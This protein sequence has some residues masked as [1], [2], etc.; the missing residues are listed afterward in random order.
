MKIN[1][2]NTALNLLDKWDEEINLP[3]TG[4]ELTESE[5]KN[6]GESLLKNL[7][8]TK[9][10]FGKNIQYVSR[11]F[12]EAY[13]KGRG[14][15][16]GVFDKEDIMEGG[17]LIYTS[18]SWTKTIFYYLNVRATDNENWHPDY[19]LIEFSKHSKNDFKS[20]DV[21]IA[22]KDGKERTFLW[23]GHRDEGRDHG[24][25]FAFLITFILFKKYV[26]LETKEIKANKRGYH[27]GTKYVNETK[28][29]ITIL[30]STWFTTIVRSEGF[31]VRGHFRMQPYGPGATKR[32]LQWIPTFEKEGYTRIAK[33]LR[34]ESST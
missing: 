22:S 6:F 25:W 8:R 9:D 27:A 26:A 17:T 16:A 32:R 5:R 11:P 3:E 29:N 33:M 1:Y 20:L 14:K 21:Y 31:A 19:T 28:S 4:D 18:D 30:D 7:P 10:L 15:L 13:L 2:K 24:H 23:K 12:M 34:D